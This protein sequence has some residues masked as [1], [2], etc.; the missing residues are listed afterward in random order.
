M[1]AKRGRLEHGFAF[2][3]ANAYRADRIISVQELMDS[4]TQEYNAAV[5]ANA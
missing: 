4:L 2:A 3:G 1:N 5:V